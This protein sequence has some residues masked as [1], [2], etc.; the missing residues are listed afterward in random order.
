[1]SEE[2]GVSI[3]NYLCPICG[4]VAEQG[5]MMNSL[6]TKEAAKEVSELNGK[7]IGFTNYACKEC[8]KYKDEVVFFIGID[9]SKSKPD[10][11]YRTG[12]I[13]GV[14]KDS[15]L[16]NHVKKHILTLS[17]D[18]QYVYIDEQAGKQIGLW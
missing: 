4:K 14:K 9:V 8:S 12:Q 3:V 2:L 15:E 13:V 18:S 5:I 16:V 10:S 17:D 11:P 6:L 1:M 7:N